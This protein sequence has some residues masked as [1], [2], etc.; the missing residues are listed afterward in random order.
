MYK[1]MLADDEGLVIESLRYMID[2]NFKGQCEV[3]HAKTGRAVIELAESFRPDLAFMDIQM[4]GINGIEAIKE[5]KK[6]SPA[7]IFVILSAYD[8]FD[9][10]KEAINLGVLEYL[11]KPTNQKV[12]VSVIQ[13]AFD[14]IDNQREHRRDSLRIKEKLEIVV[15]MMESGFVSEI[16]LQG[17]LSTSTNQYKELLGIYQQYGTMLILEYG[18]DLQ[19]GELTN[20][21]GASV[22]FQS[23]YTAVRE[24]IKEYMPCI[25]GP[26]LTN[27]IPC[28]LPQECQEENYENRSKFIMKARELVH[29]LNHMFELR[30]RIGIGSI[31][32]IQEI[33]TSYQEALNALKNTDHTIAHCKDLP[34]CCEYEEDYPTE[35]ESDLFESIRRGNEEDAKS[36]ATIFFQWMEEHFASYKMDIK[37]KVLEFVLLA[38]HIAY[39]SG[40]MTYHFRARKD[41]LPELMEFQELS[42]VERWFIAKIVIAARNVASKKTEYTNNIVEQAKAYIQENYKKDL[43]LEFVSRKVDVSSY[44]FSKLFKDVSGMNFIEY[45]TKVRISA[46]KKLLQDKTISIKE[47]CASCGYSDP[48][49]FSR[50]FKKYEGI[51]PSEFR[52]GRS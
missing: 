16:L 18:D 23:S 29:K 46:A 24:I 37:L 8:K 2:K 21:V 41:Y 6:T 31:R 13:K 22:R 26:M 15:P 25:V 28:F 5:I 20:P 44:Y 42:E 43:S 47:V 36:A 34:I 30:F 12:I 49:Y 7:T 38:E 17:K 27:K 51:T 50:I 4:P 33:Y 1:V 40:G 48:N 52:E 10:A 3:K 14:T 39:E 32:S 35:V 19:Q 45:V 9:Y 11:Q